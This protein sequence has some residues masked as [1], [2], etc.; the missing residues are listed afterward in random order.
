MGCGGCN[1]GHI[2]Y[3]PANHLSCRCTKRLYHLGQD[4]AIFKLF[5]LPAFYW[6]V[7]GKGQL[8]PKTEGPGCMLSAFFCARRGF[9]F[10]MTAEELGRVNEYRLTQGRAPLE[11]SP[12]NINFKYGKHADG[13]WDSAKFAVQC[14]DMQDCL[15]VLYPDE[16]ILQ[17][18]DQSAGHLAGKED[19]LDVDRMNQT[20]GGAQKNLHDT[21]IKALGAEVPIIIN[22]ITHVPYQLA[23]DS[24]QHMQFSDE[25]GTPPPFYDPTA[26]LLDRP[27]TD[28]IK[29]VAET[30]KRIKDN[31][32][33]R[34]KYLKEQAA[35]PNLELVEPAMLS[36]DPV[37]FFIPGYGG[38]PKGYKQVL[39]ERGLWVEG[40]QGTQSQSQRNILIL[41]NRE[42][43]LQP[44]HFDAPYVLS[45][46]PDFLNEVTALQEIYIARGNIL[47]KSVV[48][49][50]EMAGGG[51]EYAWGKLKYE[52]RQRN[53]GSVNKLKAGED[54]HAAIQALVSDPVVLPMERIWK[55][56]RR[57]RDYIRVYRAISLGIGLDG[58][59]VRELTFT[60][61][62]N[63][64]K[65]CKSH[66]CTGEQDRAFIENS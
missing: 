40:M 35:S 45:Q 59:V 4:E 22:T 60:D 5:A 36:L 57:A 66:R 51:V 27:L 44:K 30:A 1:E 16:Q 33:M 63:M 18:V 56:Q 64:R 41:S 7:K 32:R 13:Y 50:P 46:Q 37:T 38:K 12:G 10:P 9:G 17:E 48:C 29:I 21:V 11:K 8:R 28:P 23:I 42:R 53:E 43:E 14:V 62:E 15:F 26:E 61:I 20:Y 58:G 2:P 47:F 31:A 34:A 49:H 6:T 24:I 65:T 39:W 25:P 54:F 3:D 55:Y 52:Q 19:A